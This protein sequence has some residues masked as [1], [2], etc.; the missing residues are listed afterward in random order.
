MYKINIGD[1]LKKIL[2]ICLVCILGIG[3][4]LSLIKNNENKTLEN[5][6]KESVFDESYIEKIPENAKIY[7]KNFPNDEI[8]KTKDEI[9][10]LNQEIYEKSGSMFNLKNINKITKDEINNYITNYKL[11]TLPKYNKDKIVT[12]EEKEFIL[13]NRNLEEIKDIENP[14]HGV[15]VKR[16]NL[17]SFPTDINF[18]DIEGVYN[19][20]SI[21]ET[22]LVINTEV[23]IL[24]ESKDK[25]WYFVL[26]YN[27]AGWVLKENIALMSD[28]DRTFFIEPDDFVVITDASVEIN[29]K[30]LDMGSKLPFNKTKEDGYEVF[31]PVKGKD[32]YVEKEKITIPRDKG[33]IGYLD[34]TKRNVIIEAFKYENVPYSWGGLDKNVDCSSYVLNIY[35]TFGF[36]FPR[37]TKE[38]NKSI[39]TIISLSDKSKEEK[40]EIIKDKA[41]ALLYQ[42]GHVMLYLGNVDGKDYIIHASGEI[43][44]MKVLVSELNNSSYL[45]KI[46]QINTLD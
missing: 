41:P 27:Y 38:Q 30:I 19:F 32:D 44:N 20:D 21:Q 43:K 28:D 42:K 8:L 45:D 16:A 15:I 10:V 5:S 31:I 9:K 34:Y 11:P 23:I 26:T 4:I 13:N 40:L 12:S 7:L 46:Y 35:R 25:K 37:N 24:N 29:N 33:H 14:I 6:F 36:N 22:E 3:I 39:G 17:R 18:F 2:L 1:N